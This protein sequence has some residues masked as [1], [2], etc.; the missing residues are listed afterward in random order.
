MPNS[1]LRGKATSGVEVTNVSSHGVWILVDDREFFMPYDEF[2]WFR[3]APIGGIL[4]VEQPGPGHLYWPDLDVDLS[5]DAIEHPERFPLQA[6]VAST[7]R[8]EHSR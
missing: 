7:Q 5:I 4:N 1:E 2:P 8:P 6:G 3:E